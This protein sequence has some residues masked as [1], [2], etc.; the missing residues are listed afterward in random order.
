MAR[1]ADQIDVMIAEEIVSLI[2]QTEWDREQQMAILA[3]HSLIHV[4]KIGEASQMKGC[5]KRQTN[6]NTHTHIHTEE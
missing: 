3:Q 1:V 5:S 6:K 4:V 2:A